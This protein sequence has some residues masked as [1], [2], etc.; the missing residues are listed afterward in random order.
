[1]TQASL[2]VP[3]HHE[4]RGKIW[5]VLR[6]GLQTGGWRRFV[7]RSACSKRKSRFSKRCA[8]FGARSKSRPKQV[9]SAR[10]RGN[11]GERNASGLLEHT[12]PAHEGARSRQR[13]GPLRPA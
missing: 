1:M 5:A 10:H 3:V 9:I 11:T 7:K 13:P 8:G 2:S 4:K 6:I 12:A